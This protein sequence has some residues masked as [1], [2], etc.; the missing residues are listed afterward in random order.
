[1]PIRLIL[2][3]F[4]GLSLFACTATGPRESEVSVAEGVTLKLTAP[5]V[6]FDG[7]NWFWR[8]TIRPPGQ[9]QQVILAQMVINE[10]TLNVVMMTPAGLPLLSI[11]KQGQQP[12]S[13][14]YFVPQTQVHAASILAD[15]QL[16][17]WPLARVNAALSGGRLVIERGLRQLID[18]Q[19]RIVMQIQQQETEL[20][21]EHKQRGYRIR[22][23]EIE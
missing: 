16:A 4:I 21:I 14:N 5:P 6:S 3:V 23:A 13:A 18:G 7:Q 12:L 20:H 8:M 2:C 22:L 17:H 15:I 11:E 9:K 10:G 1:M 19:G